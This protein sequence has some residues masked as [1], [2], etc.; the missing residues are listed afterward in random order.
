MSKAD[1]VERFLDH[2]TKLPERNFDI[3]GEQVAFRALPVKKQREI[4]SG[5]EDATSELIVEMAR[6]PES[7]ERLF[8][9]RDPEEL[10]A[11]PAVAGSWYNQMAEA[12]GEMISSGATGQAGTLS[13]DRLQEAKDTAA[14]LYDYVQGLRGKEIDEDI[15]QEL[16]ASASEM[17][18]LLDHTQASRKEAEGNG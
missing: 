17:Q 15:A 7:G 11:A 13:D 9:G 16:M 8:A 2:G 1:L 6:D 4:L 3:D 5:P 10:E 18:D 12:V 14:N